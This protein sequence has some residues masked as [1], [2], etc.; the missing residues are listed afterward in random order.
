MIVIDRPSSYHLIT[1][2]PIPRRLPRH[3][4]ISLIMPID[5]SVNTNT[6]LHFNFHR[7]DDMPH[8][9]RMAAIVY[10]IYYVSF[11]DYAYL[12]EPLRYL[13]H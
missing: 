4:T 5:D 10:I 3:H 8:C 11:I 1:L 2:S 7:S 6:Y 12:R 9:H 13:R